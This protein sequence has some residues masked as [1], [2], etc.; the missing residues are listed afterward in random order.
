[1]RTEHDRAKEPPA[2]EAG[3]EAGGDEARPPPRLVSYPLTI[4]RMRAAV[5]EANAEGGANV[6]GSAFH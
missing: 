3:G 2:T 6:K 5:R 1:M 4:A